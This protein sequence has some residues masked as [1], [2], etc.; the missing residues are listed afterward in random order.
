MTTCNL[1][2]T[3]CASSARKK[4]THSIIVYGDHYLQTLFHLQSS[5]PAERELLVSG[6]LLPFSNPTLT[7]QC[8]WNPELSKQQLGSEHEGSGNRQLS[9]LAAAFLVILRRA[10][11]SPCTLCISCCSGYLRTV[12]H[13]ASQEASSRHLQLHPAMHW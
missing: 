3:L 11:L 5:C 12:H 8:P 9:W 1:I 7:V 6:V 4:C 13:K 2:T 10:G